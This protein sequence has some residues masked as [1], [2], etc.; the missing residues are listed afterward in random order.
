MQKK[1]Q[2]EGFEMNE[3]LQI[4]STIGTHIGPGAFGIVFVTAN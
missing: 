3:M 4:G 1:M 2:K